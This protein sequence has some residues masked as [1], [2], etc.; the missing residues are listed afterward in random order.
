MQ[1]MALVA[2]TLDYAQLKD[3]DLVIEAVFES[4]EVKK[5][6]F[7]KLDA[8]GEAGSHSRLQHFGIESR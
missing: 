7:E 6:V 1:R 3:V 8:S 2:P 4:M 5:Q